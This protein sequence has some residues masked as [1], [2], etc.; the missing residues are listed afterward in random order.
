MEVEQAEWSTLKEY[1]IDTDIQK[2][3]LRIGSYYHI[4]KSLNLPFVFHVMILS[5]SIEV[6]LMEYA[7]KKQIIN[8]LNHFHIAF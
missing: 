2:F 6:D 8:E 4:L 5:S 7:K 3:W 1:Q